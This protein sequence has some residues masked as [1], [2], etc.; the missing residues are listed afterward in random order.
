MTDLVRV[1]PHIILEGSDDTGKTTLARKLEAQG[2][3]YQHEGPAPGISAAALLDRYLGAILGAKRPTVFD[4]LHLGELVYGPILRGGSRLIEKHLRLFERVMRAT[5]TVTVICS[6]P[7]DIVRSAWERRR[8][9]EL[10][11]DPATLW[12][13]YSAYR[14]LRRYA[15]FVTDSLEPRIEWLRP[16]PRLPYGYVGNPAARF[17]FVGEQSNGTFD[18]PFLSIGGSSDYL[19]EAL[20]RAGFQEKEVALVNARRL[21]GS[22]TPLQVFPTMEVVIALGKVAAAA[23]ALQGI[24]AEELP[25]PQ[26]WNRFRHHEKIE[27]IKLLRGLRNENRRPHRRPPVSRTPV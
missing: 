7:F 25:H 9:K 2:W 3:A 13:V 23:C 12:L 6:P 19:N 11:Q 4:R 21:N 27:Y 5:A 26:Y 20:D 16:R 1:E 15:D 14:R 18:E 22:S 10:L 17:L 8:D 24:A